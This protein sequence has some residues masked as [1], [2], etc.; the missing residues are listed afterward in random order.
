MQTSRFI[1][2]IFGDDPFWKGGE[3]EAD[4]G[5]YYR[6]QKEEGAQG[7]MDMNSSSV[8]RKADAK[9]NGYMFYRRT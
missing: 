7:V 3:T 6:F 9:Q 2:T 1:T 4:L 8:L 5:E